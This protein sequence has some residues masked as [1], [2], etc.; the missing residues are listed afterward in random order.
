MN[1]ARNALYT[2]IGVGATKVA[3]VMPFNAKG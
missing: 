2:D 1:V 3:A